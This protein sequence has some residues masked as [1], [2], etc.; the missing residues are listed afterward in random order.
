MRDGFECGKSHK[1]WNCFMILSL[2]RRPLAQWGNNVDGQEYKSWQEWAIKG[3]YCRVQTCD[4]LPSHPL[5]PSVLYL[6]SWLQPQRLRYAIWLLSLQCLLIFLWEGNQHWTIQRLAR[7]HRCKDYLPWRT[8]RRPLDP[9]QT[10]CIKHNRYVLHCQIRRLLR[11]SLFRI[12]WRSEL[13]EYASHRVL[14][15]H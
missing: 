10:R 3:Q 7:Q 15:C 6:S 8:P 11:W 9:F 1:I 12:Q 4:S 2:D 5:S 13:S 14:E